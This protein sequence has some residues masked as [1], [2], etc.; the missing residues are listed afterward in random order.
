MGKIKR[1]GVISLKNKEDWTREERY[2]PYED[3]P[4]SHIFELKNNIKS[5]MWQLN[6]HI[7]PSSGLLNDPNGFS[8]FNNQWHLFYQSYP[9]GAV[10][11]IKSWYHVSSDNLVDWKENGTKLIPDSTYDSHGVYSGSALPVLDQLFLS[12]TGNVRDKDWTRHSYQLGAW[13]KSDG[14]V[15]KIEEPLISNPPTGYT[16]E[17]RDPQIFN[18]RDGYMMTIGAQTAEDKGKILTYFSSDLVHWDLKGELNFTDKDMGFMIECPNL[19]IDNQFALLIFCPQGLDQ[20]VCNYDNIYPNT[21]IVSDRYNETNNELIHPRK[22]KNLDEGFDVY[23]TQAFKAPDGRLLS[24]SWVGLPEIDYPTDSEDWAH[25]LSIVKE[26]SIKDG[27]LYQYPVVEMKQLRID[28]GI[29]IFQNESNSFNPSKNSYELELIFDKLSSGRLLLYA[30][31]NQQ[32]GLT[33]DFNSYDGKIT[34]DRSNVSITFAEEFGLTRSFSIA[35]KPLKLHIFADTS[36]VEVF[37]N[38]GEQVATMRIFPS[39][40]ET[41]LSIEATEK[42]TVT[43]WNLRQSKG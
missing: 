41:S 29:K 13:M 23:A 37:I 8:F 43:L 6:Y 2:L 31:N 30:D 35:R 38:D 1:F 39:A 11:G 32:T 26:L 10:H 21:Y 16:S 27:N 40:E 22:I 12:Y 28:D 36:I 42:Y 18:Y 25:C 20:S 34:I 19:L 7:Q 9:M 17:F 15:N 5:S 4:K 33:I 24:I 14:T 3:W